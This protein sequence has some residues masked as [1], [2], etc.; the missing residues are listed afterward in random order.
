MKK[1]IFILLAMS[2]LLVSF[3][4]A[5]GNGT[6]NYLKISNVTFIPSYRYSV[7]NPPSEL[8]LGCNDF[9]EMHADV[10]DAC[11]GTVGAVGVRDVTFDLLVLDT[12]NSPLGQPLGNATVLLRKSIP[13]VRVSGN[14]TK[15]HYYAQY[16]V[17]PVFSPNSNPKIEYEFLDVHVTTREDSV[18]YCEVGFSGSGIGQSQCGLNADET[19]LYLYCFGTDVLEDYPGFSYS[20]RMFN[21]T[22][23]CSSTATQ[24]NCTIWNYYN[25]SWAIV[26]GC[27]GSTYESGLLAPCDYCDPLWTPQYS[28]CSVD[29]YGTMTGTMAKAYTS[30][31]RDPNNPSQSCGDATRNT[32]GQ[33]I[34]NHPGGASDTKA[35]YD[36]GAEISCSIDAWLRG[37][38][39]MYATGKNTIPAIGD[40][41]VVNFENMQVTNFTFG[42]TFQPLMFDVDYDGRNDVFVIGSG[43]IYDYSINPGSNIYLKRSLN[44]AYTFTGQ[45]AIYGV[46]ELV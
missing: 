37:D 7:E 15:G 26:A 12:S 4:F 24:S 8:P 34:F 32:I 14:E 33:I 39:D 28:S 42:S 1:A 36:S 5:Q 6:N 30:L 29:D 21:S 13:G 11:Q 43:K 41:K 27:E 20:G 38:H 17:Y 31:G 22:C 46:E 44:T 16:T 2:I 35:P 3:C 9:M 19:P 25:T 45:P 23:L 10:E 40:K 18:G